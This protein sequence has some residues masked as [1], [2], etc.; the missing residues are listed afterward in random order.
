MV[1]PR[2]EEEG[3]WALT[4]GSITASRERVL[5]MVDKVFASLEQQKD[6]DGVLPTLSVH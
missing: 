3:E 1:A 4:T 5:E 2:L 6:I